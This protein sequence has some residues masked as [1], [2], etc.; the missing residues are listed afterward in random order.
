MREGQGKRG[1]LGERGIG[2]ERGRVRKGQ[3]ERWG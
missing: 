3:S 2:R 1:G